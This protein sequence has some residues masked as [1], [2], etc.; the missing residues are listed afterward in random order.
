MFKDNRSGTVVVVLN[1]VINHNARAMGAARCPGINTDLLK[2]LTDHGAGIIQMPCPER[3]VIDLPRT[4]SEGTDIRTAMDTPE[5]LAHCQQLVMGVVA[6]IK[7]F[8]ACGY[9]VPAILGGDVKS[10]GCA[11][12]ADTTDQATRDAGHQWGIFT[13]MLKTELEK[14]GLEIPIRGIRDSAEK[15]LR[16][17]LAWLEE[18]LSAC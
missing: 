4:R 16:A 3:I 5:R 11:V 9:K 7:E 14:Q 17:D 6:E 18:R 2:V 8:L 1:C 13:G 15:T 10:P 12:P